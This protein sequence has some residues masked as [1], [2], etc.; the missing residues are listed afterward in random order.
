MV[1]FVA[2]AQMD[3]LLA[4]IRG[5]STIDAVVYLFSLFSLVGAVIWVS[6]SVNCV[7]RSAFRLMHRRSD[8]CHK[9]PNLV[10][11]CSLRWEQV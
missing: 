1:D 7:N 11:W 6:G 8:V 4:F 5:F 9:W 10:H 3:T 2:E